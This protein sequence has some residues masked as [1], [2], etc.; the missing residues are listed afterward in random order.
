M[1]IL[2]LRRNSDNPQNFPIVPLP[3][4]HLWQ[5]LIANPIISFLSN[6]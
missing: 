6:Q 2:H 1:R 5:I 4:A 3:E